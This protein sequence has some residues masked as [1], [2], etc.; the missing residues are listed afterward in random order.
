MRIAT[1][2]DI[3]S[4]LYALNEV[5]ADIE[6]R[7][8]DMVVCTGDLVGYATRPNEVIETLRKNKVLTIMGN[9]DEAIGNFKIICGCD[10][11]DPKDAEN[12]SLSMKFTSEETTDENKAYLRN[13][14]KEAVISFN[15]KTIR[16]VHG[17][18]R[19]INEYLKEN[20]KEANEVMN[21]LDEDI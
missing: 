21:N 20:S 2:S 19:L 13:L 14:P 1:I 6:K 9:Y 17:S 10:Y 12:A 4:N 5:L 3:H 7:N 18:T 8:V 15:N 11:P 16:F